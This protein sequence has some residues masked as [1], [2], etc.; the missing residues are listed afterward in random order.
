MFTR[1][2]VRQF[3]E[4]SDQFLV[5]VAHLDVGHAVGMQ[6]DLGE[7]A[8]REIQQT[9]LVELGDLRA[10]IEPVEDLTGLR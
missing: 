4:P 7:L 8:E 3:G 10:E 5:E 1:R 2:L 6:V 9:V